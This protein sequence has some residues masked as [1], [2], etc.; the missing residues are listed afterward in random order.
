M[1]LTDRE[2]KVLELMAND[3]SKAE[4]AKIMGIS[5]RTIEVYQ[6]RIRARMGVK[7]LYT[8][9]FKFGQFQENV[10]LERNNEKPS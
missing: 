1:I 10:V 3:L 5:K 9:L 8:A 4:I 6:D 7:M 2:K